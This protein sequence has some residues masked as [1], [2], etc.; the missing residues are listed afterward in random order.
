MR[1]EFERTN[2]KEE[3]GS[4]YIFKPQILKKYNSRLGG[5]I[6]DYPMD[7]LSSVQ[8]DYPE[9]IPMVENILRKYNE[10]QLN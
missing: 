10:Y 4:I 2:Y 9:D 5:N 8:I 3:N 6:S 7:L 1:Q